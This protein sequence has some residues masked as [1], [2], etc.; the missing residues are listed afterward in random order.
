VVLRPLAVLWPRS[1][2]SARDALDVAREI[3]ITGDPVLLAERPHRHTALFALR[4]QLPPELAP[5]LLGPRHA[6]SIEQ[7]QPPAKRFSPD[8]YEITTSGV[9]EFW[10]CG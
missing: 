4:E 7:R 2:A 1:R 8:A 6:P 3:A 5:F 9:L 10:F